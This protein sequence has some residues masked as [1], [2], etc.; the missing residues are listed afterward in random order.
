MSRAFVV[1]SSARQDV[2]D[3]RE[4]LWERRESAAK[5]FDTRLAALLLRIDSM[6]FLYGKLW[7]NVRAVPISGFR[8]VLYYVVYRDRVEV[9]AVVHGSRQS[10]AWKSRV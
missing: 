10:S 5:K 1:R 4:Y 9:I 3:I 7:R 6:P 2:K 8:Y